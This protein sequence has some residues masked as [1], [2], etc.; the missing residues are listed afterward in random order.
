MPSGSSQKLHTM[1]A[2][3]ASTDTLDL[4]EASPTSMWLEDYSGLRKLFDSW[5]QA[6]VTDFARYAVQPGADLL[7]DLFL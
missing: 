1:G 4:F 2:A 6:G 7:P 3:P 5:R